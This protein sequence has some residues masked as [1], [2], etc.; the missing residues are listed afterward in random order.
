M[1][2]ASLLGPRRQAIEPAEVGLRL[3]RLEPQRAQA[4]VD[5]DAL[6]DRAR[7]AVFDGV[8]VGERLDRGGLGEGVAEER[9]ADLVERP[10]Q[11]LRAAQRE[12][13]AQPA[14]AVDLG[15]GAQQHEV[16]CAPS[17]SIE[18]SGSSSRLNS[19]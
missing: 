3:G 8:L 12:A 19:Q 9:L 6:G 2:S 14:Q 4:L 11:L 17:S 10:R 5:R 15:E 18:A 16:G 7:D 13:D 1:T